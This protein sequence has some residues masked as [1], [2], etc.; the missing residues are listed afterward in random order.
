MDPIK[1]PFVPGAG[2]PPPQLSGREDILKKADIALAR[3]IQGRPAK[4]LLLVGLRGVGKTV[5]LNRMRLLA[6]SHNYKTAMI[7]AHEDKSLVALLVPALRHILFSLDRYENLSDL[8]K[9]ALRVLKGFIGAVKMG[10]GGLEVGVNLV[11]ES[12]VADSGD[13]EIDL[14]ELFVAVAEAAAAKNMGV[15][16]ILD[17]M[18]YLSEEELS[19]LVMSVH[20]ISQRQLPLIVMG[21][22]L[23]HLIASTG[24]SKSYA[25]R[26]FEVPVVGA[27]SKED[28]MQALAFPVQQEGAGFAVD[29]LEEIV[30]VTKGYPYYLQEWGYHVW[31]EA[32]SSPITLQVVRRTYQTVM[33]NLDQSFFKV[34]FDRLTQREKLYLRAMAELGEGPHKSGDIAE[35]MKIKVQTLAP[36]RNSLIKK[37]M[38]YS[39]SHGETAFTVPLFDRFIKRVVPVFTADNE[40]KQ[41]EE[42]S[43]VALVS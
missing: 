35:M 26:L 12:G 25:E 17:E 38:I 2:T 33:D 21:A 41:M 42:E 22:G 6:E 32:E 5:L 40:N 23:P 29:A 37:G 9:R 30:R 11:A 4:G 24:K 31:N 15:A 43:K 27:L 14:P 18:Q 34:R 36:L 39:P 3:T 1:N 19:A 10:V 20:Q 8:A 13:L 28:A 7:E 16:I